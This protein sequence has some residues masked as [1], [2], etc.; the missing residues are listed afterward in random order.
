MDQRYL[1]HDFAAD[2]ADQEHMHKWATLKQADVQV[3]AP[4]HPDFV[5]AE[6]VS[7]PLANGDQRSLAGNG[8][9]K[10]AR[11]NGAKSTKGR[12]RNGNAVRP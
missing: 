3:V 10:P 12:R 4:F 9:K 2:P 5:P 8:A 6:P 11:K 7:W 1:L